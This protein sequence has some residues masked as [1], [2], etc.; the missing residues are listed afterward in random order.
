MKARFEYITEVLVTVSYPHQT[1]LDNALLDWYHGRNDL[2]GAEFIDEN[3]VW[4]PM[5]GLGDTDASVVLIGQAPAF[6]FADDRSEDAQR[7]EVNSSVD[8]EFALEERISPG[9][10]EMLRSEWLVERLQTI[11]S[12]KSPQEVDL[13]DFSSGASNRLGPLLV[14]LARNI[15]T[16]ELRGWELDGLYFTNL[17]KDG[18]F[19]KAGEGADGLT[20]RKVRKLNTASKET[21]SSYI[22]DEIEYVDPNV[23]ITAGLETS[24]FLINDFKK[25]DHMYSII[26]PR[27]TVI[28][29]KIIPSWHWSAPGKSP[30]NW[31][32]LVSLINSIVN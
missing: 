19:K 8:L 21:W 17:Q 6:T 15:D 24:E 5:Y 9:D 12:E 10:I 7:T 4:Y 26:P 13:T 14:W 27:E 31:N 29:A 32:E 18:E 1:P 2:D 20:P 28:D 11:L 3:R 25:N 23:V 16:A 22:Q 30:E